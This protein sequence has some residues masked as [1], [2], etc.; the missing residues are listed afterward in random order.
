ML[1]LAEG[2]GRRGWGDVWKRGSVVGSISFALTIDFRNPQPSFLIFYFLKVRKQLP[3][4][5]LGNR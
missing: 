4:L 2:L 5:Q 3:R 1:V